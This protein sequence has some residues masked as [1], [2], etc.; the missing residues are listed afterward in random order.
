MNITFILGNGFDIQ[1]GLQ[2]R[3]SDFLREYTKITPDDN[4]NIKAFKKYLKPKPNR[5]LWSDA[6][7]GMGVHLGQFSDKTIEAYNERVLDFESRLAE[8]LRQQQ[9]RCS[10]SEHEKIS[11]GFQ[12]FLFKSFGDALTSRRDNLDINKPERNRFHFISFNYTN[13]LEEIAKCCISNSGAVRTRVFQ[14]GVYT[15]D[16]G[17]IF[18]VHGMLDG[19]IIMGVNDESQLDLSGEVTLTEALRWELIKPILNQNSRNFD[20][21]AKKAIAVSDIIAI[22]GVSYGDTDKLW[23]EEI[24]GWLRQDAEHKLVMFV[25]EEPIPFNPVLGWMELN[26][27]KGKRRE[28][29]KKL[30]VKESAPDFEALTEQIYII[31]NTTRLNL[32]ELL[33]PPVSDGDTVAASTNPSDPTAI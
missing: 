1:L 29:L 23:W 19:Q 2:S 16:W 24:V 7:K 33:I 18:H 13:L 12:D 9:D 27:E 11:G 14:R 20:V 25:R 15:D 26:Y 17:L 32:K 5:D 4:E 28:M 8:Y 21:P 31:L 10:Y 22:Y 6:E 30:R 3:Y